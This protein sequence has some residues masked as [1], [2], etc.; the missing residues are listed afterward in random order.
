MNSEHSEHFREAVAA[1]IQAI[2]DQGTWVENFKTNART[3]IVLSQWVFTIKQS[4]DG[5]VKK[6]K[7]RCVLRRDLQDYMN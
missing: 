3:P 6:S 1:E 4:P 2:V 7:A 5:E